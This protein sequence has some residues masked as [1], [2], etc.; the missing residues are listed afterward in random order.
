MV[1]GVLSTYLVLFLK[2]EIKEEFIHIIEVRVLMGR[3]YGIRQG[4]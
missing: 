1:L 3:E 2:E 4:L